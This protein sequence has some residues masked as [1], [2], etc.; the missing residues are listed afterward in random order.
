V[1]TR[2]FAPR[3][4]AILMVRKKLEAIQTD[5]YI[6]QIDQDDYHMPFM[7]HPPLAIEAE[8]QILAHCM[9]TGSAADFRGLEPFMFAD[10]SNKDLFDA[11][12][13]FSAAGQP[14]TIERF[15]QHLHD[16]CDVHGER[17]SQ[18]ENYI[19]YISNYETKDTPLD[20][21]NAVQMAWFERAGKDRV[22][23]EAGRLHD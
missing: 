10:E 2:Q 15:D 7:N 21:S 4:Y 23:S 6:Q 17:R 16:S 11:I 9:K 19:L 5:F 22:V 13:N 18:I 8:M 3:R 1:A 14:C 20:N 12:L